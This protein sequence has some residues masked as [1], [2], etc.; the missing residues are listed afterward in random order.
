MAAA[1]LRLARVEDAPI[2][3][4]VHV[5]CW[6]E[7]YAG[8]LPEAMLAGLS[9][10]RRAAAWADIIG[11][12]GSTGTTVWVAEQE[13]NIVGFGSCGNQREPS[14]TAQGFEAEFTA[15]YILRAY[16]GAELGRTLMG[17]MADTL[18]GQ[19]KGS[20]ALWVL[21]EN[22]AARLFYERIGGLL[23]G[24]KQDVRPYATLREVAYG[25]RDISCLVS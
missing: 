20:A 16:Q 11:E 2:L 12:S 15:I 17:A 5:S 19:G 13:Q 18:R 6:R 9:A 14:L 22:T 24:E 7:T 4:D 25:W 3:G 21:H 10:E 8:L 23:V 1:H